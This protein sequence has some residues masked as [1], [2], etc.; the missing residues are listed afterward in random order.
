MTP[1]AQAAEK[2]CQRTVSDYHC[3]RARRVRLAD[4][5]RLPASLARLQGVVHQHSGRGSLPFELTVLGVL[6]SARALT[7]VIQHTRQSTS[8][9]WLDDGFVVSTKTGGNEHMGMRTLR[10]GL[11]SLAVLVALTAV[12]AGISLAATARSH[13]GGSTLKLSGPRSNKLDAS[14]TYTISGNAEGAANYLVAWEQFYPRS[15]CATTYAAESTRA[16]LPYTY[17][18]TLF[19]NRSVSGNYSASEGFAA[20]HAGKHG[21]CAYLINLTSGDTYAYAGAFWTNG[22]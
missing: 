18:L 14:F 9:R 7:G 8:T 21:M 17:D 19:L 13:S 12:P 2:L 6:Q 1:L 22:K 5:A 4:G 15:G 20:I 16:F 11:A 3:A 10:V